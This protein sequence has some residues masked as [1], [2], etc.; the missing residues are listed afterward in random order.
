MKTTLTI[1][2][3]PTGKWAIFE[4]STL[5]AQGTSPGQLLETMLGLVSNPDASLV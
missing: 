4:G 1:D 3:Y 5:V 2:I